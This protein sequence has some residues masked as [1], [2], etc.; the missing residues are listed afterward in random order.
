MLNRT[1][2]DSAPRG[3]QVFFLQVLFLSLFLYLVF[4]PFVSANILSGKVLKVL[5]G[6][7]FLIR[8]QGQEEHV[9]LRE[10]D[11]PEISHRKKAGQEPWGRKAKDF[12]QSLVRGKTVRLEVEEPDERDKYRRLLAYVFLNHIFV[13]RELILSG[14][15]FFY[16]GPFR[17]KYSGELQEAEEEAREKG[18]GVWDKRNG[19]RELPQEFRRRTQREEGLFSRFWGSIRG[20]GEK[21]APKEYA[22]PPDKI[23]GNKRSM[24]YHLP[25]SREAAR[26]NPKNR[27]LFASLEEAEKA[28]FRRAR[29]A[30]QKSSRNGL[31]ILTAPRAAPC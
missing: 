25:G 11:A 1:Q 22:V 28:G 8:V 19:L 5:D 2:R 16:P 27:V 29:P 14:N 9:R 20:E 12:A 21:S 13:N 6:D 24:I 4:A 3:R 15:A 30:P 26:V 10:I 7:T 17:G 31:E 18:R 23:V